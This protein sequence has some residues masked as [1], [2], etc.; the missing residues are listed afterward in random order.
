MFNTIDH[1]Q[2]VPSRLIL[3]TH[4]EHKVLILSF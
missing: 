2:S 4:G 1:L 3:E